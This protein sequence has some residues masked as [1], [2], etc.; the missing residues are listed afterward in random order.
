MDLDL[1]Q[2]QSFSFPRKM[3]STKSWSDRPSKS[4]VPFSFDHLRWSH[5]LAT[6]T[7]LLPAI[8]SGILSFP[9]GSHHRRCDNL[10]FAAEPTIIPNFY[11]SFHRQENV[12]LTQTL[13]WI[14]YLSHTWHCSLK[15]RQKL[16]GPSPPLPYHL[17]LSHCPL[18]SWNHE[19]GHAFGNSCTVASR[20]YCS[21][22]PPMRLGDVEWLIKVW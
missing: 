1:H 2:L 6:G 7:A 13:N 12:V 5:G 14:Y 11:R 16:D 4:T 19:S 8:Q 15:R 20:Y 10:I 18:P 21:I 17:T 22:E 9:V 3:I